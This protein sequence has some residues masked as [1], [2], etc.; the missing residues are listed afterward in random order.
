MKVAARLFT[1]M[2][3]VALGAIACR[4]PD[5]GIEPK[6]PPNSPFPKIDR[7]DDKPESPAEVKPPK[8]GPDGG[9]AAR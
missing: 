1:G 7:P 3:V 2:L 6:V 4:Q 5:P 8:L 9:A